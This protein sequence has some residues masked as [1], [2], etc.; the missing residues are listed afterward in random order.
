MKNLW[1]RLAAGLAASVLLTAAGGG[2]MALLDRGGHRSDGLFYQATGIRPDARLLT[3]NGEAIQAE[4]YLYWL[5]YD[6]EY[7]TSYLGSVDWSAQLTE[8]MTYGD[9]AK[10][11]ALETVKTF[12]LIRRMAADNGIVLKEEDELALA[13]QKT[14]YIAYYGGEEAYGN[15]I[16]LMGVSEETF[17]RINA[18]HLLIGRVTEAACTPGGALYPGDEALEEYGAGQGMVTARLIYL[19]T[20][21]LDEAALAARRALAEDD[22]RQLQETD[23]D[24]VYER[25]GQLMEE[26]GL[27]AGE[28][29]TFTAEDAD[30][31]LYSAVSALQLQQL[32]GVI[33][34][35]NGLY[36][37]LRQPLDL[38]AAAQARFSQQLAQQ[39]ELA[40]VTLSAAYE[41]LDTGAFTARLLQLR[42][43]L[44]AQLT[45][46]S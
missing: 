37:A 36:I 20:D 26:L 41:K 27:Q 16:R 31:A 43:E 40:A 7:L 29:L 19:S 13:Q 11:D 32:S 10:A 4:E 1:I 28:D 46:E 8:N 44:A 12:A 5:A 21:G 6:S 9:Y 15:Q 34:A 35:E 18:E 30:P 33:E 24:K 25:M 14:E 17:D 23:K 42:Q 38:S 2:A 45:A 22:L 39:R 3:V